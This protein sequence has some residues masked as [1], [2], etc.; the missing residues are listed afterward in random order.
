[1]SS[2]LEMCFFFRK[3]QKNWLEH[4][5]AVTAWAL[6]FQPDIKAYCMERLSTDKSDLRKMVDEVVSTLHYRAQT[7]KWKTKVLMCLLIFFGKN[8]GALFT[9]LA[10]T[11]INQVTSTMTILSLGNLTSGMRFIPFLSLKSLDLLSVKP[12]Q[13]G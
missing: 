4:A 9:E 1:M 2:L 5:Y 12:H 11:A 13:S 8:L 3:K 10:L 6:S 7:K